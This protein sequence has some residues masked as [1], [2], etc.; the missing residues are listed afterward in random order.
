MGIT[1]LNAWYNS[2]KG[3]WDTTGWWNSANALTAVIHFSARTNNHTYDS[4]IANTFAKHSS[5]LNDYY[6]DEGWWALAWIES[7]KYSK[8]AD[9]LKMAATIFADIQKG[10]D[11]T[12]S[13][14]VWWDKKHSYKNAIPNELAFQLASA[15]YIETRETTYLNWVNTEWSWFNNSGMINANH[16]V[17]DGLTSACKNNGQT[18]WT[19]N[20]GVILGG[21]VNMFQITQNQAYLKQATLIAD[22]AVAGLVNGQDI[23][24]EPCEPNCGG[25][26]VPQFKGIFM[27]N[28]G[29]L[30]QQTKNA[31]YFTFITKNADSIWNSGRN[32]NH[33]GLFW[34]GPFDSADA[35]RQ[36][37]AMD[38]LNAALL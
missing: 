35:A 36:S 4:L 19:Y 1:A 9:H 26:D 23:L 17:N 30:Y 29:Y 33:F 25:G 13:G 31:K 24:K 3:Q 11:T 5:F 32:S 38:A 27:R 10:W 28:L 34:A 20:Q 16:L 37:S 21:L 12:C 14:G 8:N 7:Y 15:L 22:A 18:T 2:G 6:D